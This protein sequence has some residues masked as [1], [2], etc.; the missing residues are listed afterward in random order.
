MFVVSV[1][2]FFFTDL[3]VEVEHLSK[4]PNSDVLDAVDDGGLII[5]DQSSSVIGGANIQN[6]SGS[7]EACLVDPQSS[8]S[9]TDVSGSSDDLPLVISSNIVGAA[10]ASVSFEPSEIADLE[11][12]VREGHESA[13][14]R[15]NASHWLEYSTLM[16]NTLPSKSKIVYLKAYGELEN[17]LRKEKKFINGV[18]PSEHAML[19]FFFYLK[20]DRLQAPSTIWFF[21][22]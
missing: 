19:N 4:L 2:F 16:G 15:G 8:A 5:S 9:S 14:N 18:A 17:Y 11:E 1:S 20:N 10:A 21:F 6:N 7:V 13:I 3:S 22:V 12:S